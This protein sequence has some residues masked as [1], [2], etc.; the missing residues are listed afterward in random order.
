TMA[1]RG[2]RPGSPW[3]APADAPPGGPPPPRARRAGGGAGA[4]Q[5]GLDGGDPCLAPAARL[6]DVPP[7]ALRVGDVPGGVEDRL[8]GGP[9]CGHGSLRGR[10][11]GPVRNTMRETGGKPVT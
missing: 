10:A 4:P 6:P 9:C 5:R 11:L 3:G 2:A 8:V 7:P 1:A